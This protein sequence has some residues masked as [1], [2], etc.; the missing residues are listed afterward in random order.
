MDFSEFI[1]QHVDTYLSLPIGLKYI[2]RPPG[3]TLLNTH[4]TL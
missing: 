2:N 4:R 1:E 3:T